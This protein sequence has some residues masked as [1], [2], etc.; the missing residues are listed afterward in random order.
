M[1]LQVWPI[2]WPA[3]RSL[4]LTFWFLTVLGIAEVDN[5]VNYREVK[6]YYIRA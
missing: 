4:Q 1:G 6:S 3:Q 2:I 5:Y